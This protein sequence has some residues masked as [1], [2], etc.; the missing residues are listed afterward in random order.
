MCGFCPTPRAKGHTNEERWERRRAEH[1][2]KHGPKAFFDP[3]QKSNSAVT[4]NL[5]E[6]Y[7]AMLCGANGGKVFS[8]E[9]SAGQWERTLKKMEGAQLISAGLASELLA[10]KAGDLERNAL[11]F[12]S[13]SALNLIGSTHSF[14]DYKELSKPVTISGFGDGMTTSAIGV[15]T[16]SIVPKTKGALK[17]SPLRLGSV[18]HVPK[19][20]I[21][22]LSVAV[23]LDLG[24]E[25]RI[26]KGHI[27]ILKDSQF[28]MRAIRRG[29]LFFVDIESPSHTTKAVQFE[30][31]VKTA[32]PD[33]TAAVPDSAPS[34]EDLVHYRFGHHNVPDLREMANHKLVQGLPPMP[35]SKGGSPI[36]PCEPCLQ[37]KMHRFPFP[38]HAT[39]QRAAHPLELLHMDLVGPISQPTKLGAKYFLTMVDD[40]TRRV[41]V[42]LL[43]D[44]SSA[45]VFKAFH[46]WLLRM[47][48]QTGRKLGGIRTDRGKEF[49]N[50]TFRKLLEERGAKHQA[51]PPHTP[52]QN[53]VA[54]RMN[55]TLL[56]MSRS[57]LHQAG[58]HL[59]WWGE[60]LV[61]AAYVHN[62][63]ITSSLKPARTPMEAWT[64]KAP[65]VSL[66]RV[67]GCKAHALIPEDDRKHQPNSKW[68]DRRLPCIHLG[69]EPDSKSWRLYCL[70]K[71][72]VILSR[73]VVFDEAAILRRELGHFTA[74]HPDVMSHAPLDFE[75]VI[76]EFYDPPSEL[77]PAHPDAPQGSPGSAPGG[78]G[79]PASAEEQSSGSVAPQEATTGTTKG[80]EQGSRDSGPST[81]PAAAEEQLPAADDGLPQA[82][83]EPEVEQQHRDGGAPAEGELTPEGELTQ[84]QREELQSWKKQVSEKGA[85][86]RRSE[87]LA[88]KRA[89]TQEHSEQQQ[90]QQTTVSREEVPSQRQARPK[91]NMDDLMDLDMALAAIRHP[92]PETYQ[93]AISHPENALWVEAMM[94]ELGAFKS[95]NTYTLCPLPK[96]KRAIPCRWVFAEKFDALGNLLKR[97]GRLVAKG[98]RAEKGVDYDEIFAPTGKWT[99]LR[100]LLH[101]GAAEDAEIEVMDFDN[102]F[103]NGELE[104]EV[105]M[106]QPPGF[107]DSAHPDWVWRLH[108][109]VY[110]LKQA[111]RQWYKKLRESL[112]EMGF[113]QSQND[114][115][116]FKKGKF[117]CF[118]YVDDMV[119]M[120]KDK[121]QVAAFKA[122]MRTKFN[123]K[124]LGPIG[125]Y[126]NVRVVRDRANRHIYLLQDTYIKKVLQRF[127]M[128][129]CK[130][131]S[132]PILVKH[133]LSKTT[134]EE[135]V[136]DES[137][138]SLVGSVNLCVTATRPDLAYATGLLARYMADGAHADRHWQ[139]AKRVL[140]YLQGTKQTALRLG[141]SAGVQLRGWGQEMN[142]HG[143]SDSSFGDCH[144]SARSTLGWCFSLGDGPVS[145]S[146]KRSACV[147]DS[148]TVAEYYA[149]GSAAKEALW[150]RRLL[151][152]LGHQQTEATP[153]FV[154]STGAQSV[155][156]NPGS[157]HPRTKHVDITY[158]F[159]QEH[160]EEGRVRLLDIDTKDNV[161]DLFTKALARDRHQDLVQRLQLLPLP[162]SLNN[163][164]TLSVGE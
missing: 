119:I 136:V 81:S 29:N 20:P 144:D 83:A 72:K 107:K 45:T 4:E 18:F 74:P 99:T 55:R 78:V 12:D 101:V 82:A 16:I 9:Y 19:M 71:K 89:Q 120:A 40:C 140:R 113:T 23:M 85:A 162:A 105:Y 92:K 6:E 128:E 61:H 132:T 157:H 115:A 153:I 75:A 114:P 110:G 88:N 102:A 21:G 3:R 96:G 121:A 149:A 133:G 49:F 147:A 127:G 160:V 22:L 38:K 24:F 5:D 8:S 36:S 56:G 161:A 26:H 84:K 17:K 98:F 32:Q 111:P 141:G 7:D 95:T 139:M 14:T 134:E 146:S 87:R 155:A 52:Q 76:A 164:G 35:K 42:A 129:N 131:N 125:H 104:E 106:D 60:A 150:L 77:P 148:T 15:G 1:Y 69:V 152:D 93:E 109:S 53:G 108:K 65:D 126:L 73:D 34:L 67:F 159:I 142:L 11:I 117:W 80:A 2:A 123:M 28:V 31:T 116:L 62:R 47:E 163:N 68:A 94:K 124:E 135:I 122:E 103:L 57:M 46:T 59:S 79:V 27:D 41:A 158:H 112:M 25:F 151:E 145:W 154:D 39:T 118:V 143:W 70:P 58:L 51:G 33:N 44:K 66:L 156:K 48:N 64:G 90:E 137:Y 30:P 97:K 13:G 54:E 37:G 86:P 50:Q 138:A 43:T 63:T 10:L 130:A 91:P 100:V